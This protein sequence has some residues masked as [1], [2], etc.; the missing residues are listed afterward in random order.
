M[1]GESMSVGDG[2]GSTLMRIETQKGE[3]PFNV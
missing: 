3:S 2:L 1:E